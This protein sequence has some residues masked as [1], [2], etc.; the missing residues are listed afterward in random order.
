MAALYE[1]GR[2]HHIG[3]FPTLE[4]QL[5]AFTTDF[6]RQRAGYSPDRVD[7]L[8][9]ALTELMVEK[10]ASAGHFELLRRQVAAMQRKRDNEFK[11]PEMTYAIGSVEWM[12]EQ[13]QLG[14]KI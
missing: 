10:M 1:Q 4:D 11:L 12:E 13:R 14:K 5:C 2:V 3:A 9:W 8:V 7:A 6:D